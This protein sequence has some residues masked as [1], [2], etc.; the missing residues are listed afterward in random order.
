MGGTKKL[1]IL[2]FFGHFALEV[3]CFQFYVKYFG[4]TETAALMALLYDILAFFPQFFIGAL[5]ERLERLPVGPL[6]AAMVLVGALGAFCPAGVLR[7]TG[8]FVLSL[9]NAFVHVGG[10]KATLFTCG[11]KIAPSAIF[12]SGGSFGVITGKLLGAADSSFAIGFAVMLAGSAIIFLA[13]R[14]LENAD[15]GYPDIKM[16]DKRRDTA[17]VILLAFFVVSVRGLMSYGIPT[18][19][20]R[21]ALQSFCLFAMMGVGK[22]LGGILS[23]KFGAKK[24]ALASS[25]IS[26][27]LLVAGADIMWVSLVGVAMFSM[28]MAATLGI[29]VSA[30][31]RHPLMAY[32]VTTTGLLV[33]TIPAFYPAVKRFISN[34]GFLAVL[35]LVCAAALYYIMAPDGKRAEKG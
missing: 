28:T 26:L 10:A 3:V 18:A 2:W 5:A 19:W 30:A 12:V 27:P 22:G 8:F 33:G 29:L 16:A 31:P 1:S 34:V 25:L 14:V 20:N 15:T 17:V 4:S 9:G 13:Q 24:T 35:T 7:M 11:D 32:G 6:G 23:D 21:T